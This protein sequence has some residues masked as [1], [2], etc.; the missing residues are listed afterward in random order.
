MRRRTTLLAACWGACALLAGP[1]YGAGETEIAPGA[2]AQ[3]PVSALTNI[4]LNSCNDGNPHAGPRA[5]TFEVHPS[6]AATFVGSTPTIEAVLAGTASASI[7]AAATS[8]PGTIFIVNWTAV[9]DGCYSANGSVT[10][11]VA[12]PPPAEPDPTSDEQRECS[13][14][15]VGGRTVRVFVQRRREMIDD[16]SIFST[17]CTAARDVAEGRRHVGVTCTQQATLPRGERFVT[18]TSRDLRITLVPRQLPGGPT[19]CPKVTYHGASYLVFR[20]RVTCG[21][22]R[23]TAL[24]MLRGDDPYVFEHVSHGQAPL[25]RC[26]IVDRPRPALR[27][28]AGPATERGWCHKRL[29]NRWTLYVP[30]PLARV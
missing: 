23:N 12:A 16:G 15:L 5:T 30:A 27:P 9:A 18:C 10:F 13:P 3:I 25:W 8:T 28:P 24:R 17:A 22:A 6:D 19:A 2:T 1:A 20:L 26:R 29:E 14:V 21:F 7:Q 11:I 4:V